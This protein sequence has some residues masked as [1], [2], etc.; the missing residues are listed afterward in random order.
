[1]PCDA[2]VTS[3]RGGNLSRTYLKNV[4]DVT[5][6]IPSHSRRKGATR[7][8]HRHAPGAF[9]FVNSPLMQRI[10]RAGMW[11]WCSRIGLVLTGRGDRCA[12]GCFCVA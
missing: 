1:M 5:H 11:S 2:H 3:L 8:R 12:V 4:R 7:L 9:T 10:E 6:G